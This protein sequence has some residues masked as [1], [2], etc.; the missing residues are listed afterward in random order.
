MT[1]QTTTTQNPKALFGERRAECS[2]GWKSRY[3]YHL[4]HVFAD[5]H[6]RTAK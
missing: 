3:S 5:H 1:H 4:A 2:C 6:E